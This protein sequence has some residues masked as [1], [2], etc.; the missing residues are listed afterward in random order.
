MSFELP[1]ER[2]VFVARSRWPGAAFLVEAML[3]LVFIMASL[4]LFT[5]LFAAA[6]ER[7]GESKAL[8]DAVALASTTA[9]RFAADPLAVPAEQTSG[10]LRVVCSVS[11]EAR[12]GGTLYHAVI[13]V[14]DAK[15]AAGVTKAAGTSDN[16]SGGS[17]AADASESAASVRAVPIDADEAGSSAA[18]PQA[19]ESAQSVSAM[20][21]DVPSGS[22]AS[23][24]AS[25]QALYTITTARYVSGV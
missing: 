25:G 13:S 14:Y 1:S 17:A 20:S 6:T 11:P 24:D 18:A 23:A 3:L 8:T 16:S 12:S 22:A 19:G 7:A 10:D 15:A 2:K 21:A 5:Q 4:A 9:E